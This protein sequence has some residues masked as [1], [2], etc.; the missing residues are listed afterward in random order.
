MGGSGDLGAGTAGLLDD[1]NGQ[2]RALHRVGARAQLVEENQAVAVRL[3]QNAHDIDHMCRKSGQTL[4]D[5]L[6]VA[7]VRQHFFIA[8]DLALVRHGNV[9]TALG[10]DRQQS[11]RLEA[12]GLAAGIGAG[13]DQGIKRVAQLD[14]DGHGLF[15]VQQRVPGTPQ[16]DAAVPAQGRTGG[17][18]FIAQLAP[19]KDQIQM[20]HGVVVPLDILP[21]GRRLGGELRQDPLDLLFLLGLELDELVVGLHHAH[22]LHEHRGAGGGDIMHQTRQVALV[23]GFHRYHEAAVPL[24]DDGLLQHLGIAGGRDDLLEDLTALG[25]GRSH[26]P[27]DIRQLGA[28]RVGDG[29][30]IHDAPLDLLFQEAVA[31]EGQKQMVD[32]G[33]FRRIGVEILLGP[34]GCGQQVRNGQ[35]LPGVQAAAP[36]CPVQGLRHRLDAG[37]GRTAPQADHGPGCVSLVQQPLHFLPLRLRPHSHGP[38]LGLGADSLFRE[39]LQHPGQ[40]QRTQGFIK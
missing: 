39:H 7:N 5:A 12:H 17:V 21:V 23:L 15:G 20:H 13:D 6:L 4:F 8:G 18:H 25:L 1:G 28:G 11:Q 3:L 19:G 30:L 10:H 36:V 27:A 32:G 9:Q 31:V 26:V 34:A 38:L 37:K 22:G 29:V 40:L 24:G 2:R 14:V 33:L 35:Q 16:M